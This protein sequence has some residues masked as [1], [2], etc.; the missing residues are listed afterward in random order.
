MSSQA[1]AH[2]LFDPKIVRRAIVDSFLKLDP[3]KELRNPVMFT[4]YVGSILTTAL[5]VQ[6]LLGRRGGVARLHS[7]HRGLALVH[8]VVRQ[9]RRGDGRGAGKGPGRRPAPRPAR[10][11]GQEVRSS[12]RRAAPRAARFRRC[13]NA[14]T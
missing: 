12:A 2:A 7:G 11:F 9:F 4:V 6:S 10:G 3:R 1:K 5:C 8:R 13:S 14:A